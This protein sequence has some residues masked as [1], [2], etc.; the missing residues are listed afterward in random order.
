MDMARRKYCR[1]SGVSEDLIQSDLNAAFLQAYKRNPEAPSAMMQT[2][3]CMTKFER[4]D[5]YD[6]K[7]AFLLVGGKET[8][9]DL[10]NRN[11]IRCFKDVLSDEYFH[12]KED[13]HRAMEGLGIPFPGGQQAGTKTHLNP[14]PTSSQSGEKM[15]TYENL[16]SLYKS[17]MGKSL[18][19]MFDRGFLFEIRD[20]SHYPPTGVNQFFDTHSID[21]TATISGKKYNITI[22]VYGKGVG[23]DLTNPGP[24]HADTIG[25]T[26]EKDPE[27]FS[28]LSALV[29]ASQSTDQDETVIIPEFIIH[30]MADSQHW[31]LDDDNVAETQFFTRSYRE[32]PETALP[33]VGGR[34]PIVYFSFVE[35]LK[36][37][38]VE[39]DDLKTLVSEG[40]LRAYRAGDEM[41]FRQEDVR[42]QK[43]VSQERS[44]TVISRSE[45]ETHQHSPAPETKPALEMPDFGD[46][47][48]RV[49]EERMEKY[50]EDDKNDHS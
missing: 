21:C 33:I 3:R 7:T 35:T 44:T 43:R 20:R 42:E 14:N 25:F 1:E 38:Q 8:L 29:H 12:L 50:R 28:Y 10:V 37:L 6:L 30:D 47:F 34:N 4:E 41:K 26:E 19:K 48:K 13:V 2:M 49:M 31:Y 46:I 9:H 11:E 22:T 36:E 24:N 23:V 18:H 27:I 45:V 17:D 32:K 16:E 15:D 39:E 40:T 5:C